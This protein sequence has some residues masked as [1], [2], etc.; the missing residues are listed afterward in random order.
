MRLRKSRRVVH[1]VFWLSVSML[2]VPF[3]GWT[4]GQQPAPESSAQAPERQRDC[5]AVLAVVE[6]QNRKL[7]QELRHIKRE[8][9]LLNQNME[10]PGIREVIA[11]VGFILGLFGAVALF[12]LRR[13]FRADREA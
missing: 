6:E 8:L 5:A 1:L 10:K 2:T 3:T 11:G 9:T 7:Q 4:A 13:R 12:S